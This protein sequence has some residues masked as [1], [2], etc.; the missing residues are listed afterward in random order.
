MKPTG[1]RVLVLTSLFP[2]HPGEKQGNFVLDQVRELAAQGA[3]ITVLVAKPWMPPILRDYVEK[4][5]RPI[6]PAIYAGEN[7][8]LLNSSY[9][10]LPRFALGT[11]A[12]RFIRGLVP[13][14]EYFDSR[15]GIDIIHAHGLQLGHAAVEAAARLRI[16]SV[17][18]VHG[19]ETA[20]RFDN[21]RAKRKQIGDMLDRTTKVILVGSP[22]LDYIRRFTV[23]TDHCTVIGN[24]FSGYPGLKPSTLVPRN[25][26]VRVI[27]VSNYEESKGFEVLVEAIASLDLE[28][29]GRIETVLVGAGA[30]FDALGAK[31]EQLGL[32][33]C[34]H[35]VGALSH[36]ETMAEIASA[37]IFCLPS[38][39]EAFGIMYAEA[40]SLGKL[41]VGCRG[42]GP[43]DFMRHLDTGY[44]VEPR[45]VTSVAD[46]LR[47]AIEN[48]D[49]AKKIAGHGRE[50]ALSSLTWEHNA[51]TIL[52]LYQN[53]LMK[54]ESRSASQGAAP[55]V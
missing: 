32:G 28:T 35:Y 50:Y 43:S 15:Q 55:V 22:L 48:P 45:S 20:S 47:W 1:T 8:C 5:K 27:A 4:N 33:D 30:G 3:D 29:R 36:R 53:L 37:D 13:A 6:S 19:E 12:A 25:R 11:H 34:V 17:V 40:M 21:S 54:N 39:R 26:P 14:I 16:P 42:Q 41:A 7:F 10:S 18:T 31:V 52:S 46:A 51:E 38:W 44:L 2:S 23:K 9:F 24:G 49:E